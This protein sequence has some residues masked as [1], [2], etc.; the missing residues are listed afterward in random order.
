VFIAELPW[1]RSM[2]GGRTFSALPSP[3]HV[4]QHAMWINPRNGRHIMVGNDG[5]FSMSYD[6][7]QSWNH[8]NTM[9]AVLF[10]QVSVD[11]RR[12][13]YICGGL[14]DNSSWCGPSHVRGRGGPSNSE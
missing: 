3:G 11:M 4:D 10:Y 14:Q 1:K 2:D 7:G 13:Y 5:G 6:R 12:P 8:M 9:A